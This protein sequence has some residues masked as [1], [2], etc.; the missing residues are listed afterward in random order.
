VHIGLGD[1]LC[2][3]LAGQPGVSGGAAGEMRHDRID[4]RPAGLRREHGE[5]EVPGLAPDLGGEPVEDVLE[6]L[7][8]PGLDLPRQ[9]E[10]DRRGQ[11]RRRA[12]PLLVA[13][14]ASGHS[15]Q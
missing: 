10:R 4:A 2:P 8:M 14:H 3:C 7:L 11:R 13:G 1:Q 9:H 6:R 12:R 5:V 15:N